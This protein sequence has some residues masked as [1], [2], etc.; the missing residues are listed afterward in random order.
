VDPV[1]VVEHLTKTYDLGEVQVAAL[2]GIDMQIRA[3]AFVAIMGASGSGKST[4]MNILGCLDRPT[5]GRYLLRGT[6]VS[7]ML[8]ERLAEVRNTQIGF[9]FQSFQLLPRTSALENV[10][11]PLLYNGTATRA[12]H[13]RALDALHTVGLAERAAHYPSQLSGGQQQRVALARAL[14]NHPSIILADE[15]TGNLDTQ[16]GAEIMGVLQT[17]NTQQGI[18]IVVVTHEYDVA[19]YAER[20]VTFKDGLV[21]EDAPVPEQRRAEGSSR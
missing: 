9:V 7:Q 11:L 14:V 17:L 4:F 20:V 21:V 18:T 12:R 5:S 16:T 2:R 3:G 6:D 13:A 10:E 19:H 15:P 1:I 8:S